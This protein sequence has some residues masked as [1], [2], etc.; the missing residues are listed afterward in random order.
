ML[1]NDEE[2]FPLISDLLPDL[3]ETEKKAIEEII[4]KEPSENWSEVAKRVGITERQLRNVRNDAQVQEGL[5]RLGKALFKSEIPDVL[6][7]LTKKAKEG[8]AWAVKLFLEV[9]GELN[10]ERGREGNKNYPN[11]AETASRMLKQYANMTD[12]ELTHELTERL[13]IPFQ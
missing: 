9:S 4:K 1:L 3:N 10:D 8:Q 13:K 11:I 7:I 6:K 2:I 5:Y 12:E